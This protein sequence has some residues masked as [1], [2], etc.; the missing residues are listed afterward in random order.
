[1]KANFSF[2]AALQELEALAAGVTDLQG[3][4]R[5]SDKQILEL[6]LI[7][8]ELC[9]NIIMHGGERGASKIE[10]GFK[11]ERDDLEVMIRDDGP[12]FDP[13]GAPQVD[14]HAPLEDRDPGGLGIHFVQHFADTV[15]Y[16][17][18]NDYNITLIRKK[19]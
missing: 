6:S 1:M 10:V 18:E 3:E 15:E 8:E 19:L 17:R 14:I 16:R 5:C 9:A 11:K 7:L 2:N 12:P 4:L 13:T